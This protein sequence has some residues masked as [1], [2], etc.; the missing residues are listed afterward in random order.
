MSDLDLRRQT[1]A[2]NCET[3]VMRSD[4]DFPALQVF[5]RLVASAMS[6]LELIG[7]AAKGASQQ[8]MSEAVFDRGT[9]R[10]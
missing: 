8:L 6:K 7:F 5:Y 4:L 10:I 2:I 3:M 1:L 9:K